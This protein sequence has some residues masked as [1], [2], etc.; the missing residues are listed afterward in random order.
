M[1][2]CFMN[3]YTPFLLFSRYK[4]YSII[5][6]TDKYEILMVNQEGKII[7]KFYRDIKPGIISPKEKGYFKN[8]IINNRNISDFVKKRFIRKIPRYKNYFNHIL[9]SDPYIWVFRIKDNV[10]EQ[11]SPIKVDIFNIDSKFIGTFSIKD[12]PLFISTKYIY[13]E[14][15]NIQEDLLLSKYKY[16]IKKRFNIEKSGGSRCKGEM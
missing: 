7:E 1:F 10:L 15:T 8:Q 16:D 3:E 5:G 14:E 2:N 6:V 4:K 11:D 12:L 13:F 9:I